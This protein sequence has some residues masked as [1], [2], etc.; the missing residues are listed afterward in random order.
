MRL[1][2][3][4]VVEILRIIIFNTSLASLQKSLQLVY[5]I[6]SPISVMQLLDI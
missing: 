4:Q 5:R 2:P 6:P 3:I 1:T